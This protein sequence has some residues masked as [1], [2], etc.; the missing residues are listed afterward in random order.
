MKNKKITHN[1]ARVTM[2]LLALLCCFTGAWAQLRVPSFTTKE[3]TGYD[4]G[5]GYY[6]LIASPIGDEVSP[7]NVTNMLND[8]IDLYSFD[9]NG[10]EGL[11]WRNYK[12]ESFNLE[13]GKG[14]LYASKDD[15][16]LTFTGTPCSGDGVVT[17]CRN[18]DAKFS[19]WNLVGN[20]FAG[21]A[22]VDRPFYRLNEDRTEIMANESSNEV[23]PMEGI[24][25]IAE[26]D[27]ETLTFF[28]ENDVKR[29]NFA[30]NI[31]QSKGIIDRAIVSFDESRL[32]PKFQLKETSTKIF[33]PQENG[34]FALV[35]GKVIDQLPVSFKAQRDGSYTLSLSDTE[36]KFNYLHLVDLLTGNDVDLLANPSYTFNA[37]S[38]DDASRF[39]L[40]YAANNVTSAISPIHKESMRNMC[41]KL[42]AH[43]LE[44]H[45][46]ASGEEPEDPQYESHW[47][48]FNQSVYE[49]SS[50]LV[51][52]VQINGDYIKDN[53]TQMEIAAFVGDECRGHMFMDDNTE[54]GD[55]YPIV[56]L[57]V[58][59]TEGGE[60]VTFILYDHATG[61]EYE[62]CT[63]NKEIYTGKEEVTL[64]FDYDDALVL[65]FKKIILK[66]KNDISLEQ[67]VGNYYDVQLERVFNYEGWWYTICLPFDVD[68]TDEDSPFYGATVKTLESSWFDKASGTLE[69]NF[70]KDEETIDVILAGKPYIIKWEGWEG[71]IEDPIFSNME[72]GCFEPAEIRTEAVTFKGL[73]EPLSIGSDGDKTKL[74]IGE[75][76]S[77]Y[78]PSEEMTIGAFR[79]Y[80]QLA[81]GLTCGD[82]E[83]N[84]IKSLVLNFGEDKTGIEVVNGQIAN[85]KSLWYDLSGRRLSVKPIQKGFYIHDGH[86]I[87][88]K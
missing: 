71:S 31:S 21:V 26:E 48:D 32:L 34:D 57:S 58:Y 85:G 66:D 70:T 27:G 10:E 15:V 49:F 14:Y 47:S 23:G 1:L 30:L 65:N 81:E 33:I 29:L 62:L 11:E 69:L 68:L 63:P 20:P 36:V 83:E 8:D 67:Y 50:L 38:T 64:Y 13:S 61:T 86:K 77:L 39:R 9:Q 53:Y 7:E 56:V 16:T 3:I 46:D 60:P 80:F 35:R 76:N 43:G 82:D 6:Y 40:D 44:G 19:G 87:V 55:P 84:S 79:A 28:R 52:F 12:A 51:A 88:V 24:F 78:Y 74:Y 5:E 37:R 4:G 22:T 75:G 73:F 17:L 18:W 42:P 45:Q 2:T 25:V 59:Y 41:P 54:D 72:I